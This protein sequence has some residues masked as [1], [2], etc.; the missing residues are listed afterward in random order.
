[1]FYRDE[2]Y[3]AGE[4]QREKREGDQLAHVRTPEVSAVSA[5]ATGVGGGPMFDTDEGDAAGE[6]Q[7]DQGEGEK[8]AHVVTPKGEGFSSRCRC[9]TPRRGSIARC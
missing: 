4:G 1:M 8:L 9:R 3:A 7:H 6:S 2:G 5:A